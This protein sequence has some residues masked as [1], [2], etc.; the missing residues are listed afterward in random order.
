MTGDIFMWR[1][2]SFTAPYLSVIMEEVTIQ[3]TMAKMSPK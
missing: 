2:V 3:C 1:N